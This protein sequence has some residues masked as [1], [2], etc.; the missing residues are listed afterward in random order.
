[1]VKSTQNLKIKIYLLKF[2][3][4]YAKYINRHQPEVWDAIDIGDISFMLNIKKK[5]K[6]K[7]F[8][9][10]L[11]EVAPEMLDRYPYKEPPAFASGGVSQLIKSLNK[12]I[13]SVN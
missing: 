1:M 7:P 10:F 2:S 9:F 12:L 5:L 6:C 4:D 8:K 13:K 11:E 3:S